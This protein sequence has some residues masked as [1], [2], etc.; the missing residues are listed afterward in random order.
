MNFYV[1]HRWS[2]IAEMIRG[3]FQGYYL[4]VAHPELDF[5]EAQA[6]YLYRMTWM[7]MILHV[8]LMLMMLTHWILNPG[9]S[10]YLNHSNHSY[11]VIVIIV[12]N[13][14]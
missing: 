3:G 6:D 10:I 12:I 14:A 9:T 11:L 13:G 1:F 7:I 2:E 5:L 8:L 4:P